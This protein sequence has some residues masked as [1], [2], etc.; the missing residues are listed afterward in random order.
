MPLSEKYYRELYR[1]LASIDGEEEAKKLA[2]D[3]FTPR[4][5][6]SFT[7]RWQ[8]IQLLA[9]GIPQRDVAEKLNVSISKIT[10]GSRMLRHGT[11]AF[12]HFLKKLKK[13]VHRRYLRG[14]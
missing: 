5:I 14:R 12:V 9:Q 10:R 2:H 6:R 1:L 3:L 11:G 7:M 13:P 4:E 8:E